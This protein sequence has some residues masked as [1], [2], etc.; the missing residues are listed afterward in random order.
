[1]KTALL[2]ITAAVALLGVGPAVAAE[3]KEVY[4]KSCAV[5]HASLSPKLGDKAAWAPRLKQGDDALV[6]AVVKG[7]GAMPPKGGNASLSEKD[8]KEAVEYMVSQ[9]K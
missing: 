9:A 6:A 8:I 5:C 2:S 1:M 3:G 4:T 7:K